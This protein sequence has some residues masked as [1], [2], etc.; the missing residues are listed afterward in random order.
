MYSSFRDTLSSVCDNFYCVSL[1][2]GELE[3]TMLN[4]KKHINIKGSVGNTYQ[5]TNQELTMGPAVVTF[6]GLMFQ[7][8]A[9]ESEDKGN[10]GDGELIVSSH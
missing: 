2:Q 4:D 3:E 5:C 9:D 8:F 6:K 7:P 10:F 1:L